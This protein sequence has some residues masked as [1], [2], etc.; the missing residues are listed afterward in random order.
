MEFLFG[1][2]NFGDFEDWEFV[3]FFKVMCFF[4]EKDIFCLVVD[5]EDVYIWR[6][7]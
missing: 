6:W 2:V 7:I 1:I 5:F 4:I 3:V